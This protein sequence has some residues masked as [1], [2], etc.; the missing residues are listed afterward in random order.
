M[1]QHGGGI[2]GFSA[3]TTLLPDENI[4]IVVLTNM[5]GCPVHSIVTFDA[6]ERLLGLEATPWHERIKKEVAEMKAAT[7]K[8]KEQSAGDRVPDTHP[9]HAL[10]AYTG[11]FEH[12][13]YGTVSITHDGEQ[14]QASFNSMVFPL[15]HYHYD[16]FEA[17]AE[18]FGLQMKVSFSTN[19]KGDIESVAIPFEPT[20]KEI[21]FKRV[22]S[23]EM[24]EKSFLEQFVGEYEFMGR[25][26]A[27]ALRG[28]K[29]LIASIPGQPDYELEPYKGTQFQLKGLAGFSL[30]FKKDDTGVVTEVVVTQPYGVVTAKRKM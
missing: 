14:L 23:K 4:G 12:P 20:V 30:E 21:V 24:T 9:S 13:G 15:T 1:I 16:I 29:T 22:A 7:E 27:I 18:R 25:S 26:I 17:T 28:E 11:N 6:C 10:D 19:I 3:L 2:D 8:S 5:E